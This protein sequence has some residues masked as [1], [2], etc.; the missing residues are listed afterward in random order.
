[1]YKVISYYKFHPIADPQE[2]CRLHRERCAQLGLRGRVYVA[3]EGINGTLGGSCEGISQYEEYLTG[4]DGFD[5][6]DFKEHQHDRIPFDRLSVRVRTEAIALKPGRPVDVRQTGAHLSPREWRAALESGEEVLLMD[7]RNRY[8]W[9]VG[10]FDGAVLPPLDNFYDFP[11]WLEQA[12]IPRDKKILMYCTGG[13]RCEKF[14]AFMKSEGYKDVSQ[15]EGGILNYAREENGSHFRGKCFVFDD[16]LTVPVGAQDAAPI[17]RC[18]VTG[19]PCDTYINCAN[20][21]CNRLFICSPQGAQQMEGCCSETCRA[22]VWRRPFDPADIYTPA[23]RWYR[24]FDEKPSA[25]KRALRASEKGK[26]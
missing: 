12:K 5:G 15:L 19:A 1:M 9:Q 14:S 4:L 25:E 7:V 6:I 24:Y 2:F 3:A 16:R 22:V 13:I 26:K 10:H 8:E 20:M 17:S 11:G 21:D 23:R 18:E